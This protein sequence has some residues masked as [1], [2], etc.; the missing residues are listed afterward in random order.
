MLDAA[1]STDDYAAS[2]VLPMMPSA[3]DYS[4]AEYSVWRDWQDVM[5]DATSSTD[6]CA[7]SPGATGDAWCRWQ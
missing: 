5:T 1:P 2:P 6:G 4:G 7:A 3:G